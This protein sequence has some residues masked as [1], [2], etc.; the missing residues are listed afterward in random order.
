[1]FL[2]NLSEAGEVERLVVL[3][4]NETEIELAERQLD[5]VHR[6]VRG[7]VVD[8]SLHRQ[9]ASSHAAIA[10]NVH[11]L[12]NRPAEVRLQRGKLARRLCKLL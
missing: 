9:L 11:R 2:E 1:M 12:R 7:F 8:A 5:V 3:Q 4:E 6:L 10:G